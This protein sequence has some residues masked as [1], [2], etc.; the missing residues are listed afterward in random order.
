[1]ERLD[2]AMLGRFAVSVDGRALGAFEH[3]R[4]ADLVKL[5]A[6][7][8]GHRLT[9]D[10]AVENLG[11]GFRLAVRDRA[12]RQ[13]LAERHARAVVLGEIDVGEAG[14]GQHLADARA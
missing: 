11:G 3:R 7:A 2:I 10:R 14:Q 5:L 13:P 4:A 6:L 12:I 1:M 9:R 8:P